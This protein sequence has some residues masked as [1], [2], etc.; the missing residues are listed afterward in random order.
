MFE[1]SYVS[2]TAPY[3]NITP[4][5]I[6]LGLSLSLNPYTDRQPPHHLVYDTAHDDD[7]NRTVNVLYVSSINMNHDTTSDQY[8][9]DREED[10]Q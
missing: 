7:D 10:Q 8:Y 2:H 6:R 1:H 3:A 9:Y 4:L 5:G